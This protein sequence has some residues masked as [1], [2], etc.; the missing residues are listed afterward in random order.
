[1]ASTT[2][3]SNATICVR[4]L[5][6]YACHRADRQKQK[7]GHRP[8]LA[9]LRTGNVPGAGNTPDPEGITVDRNH[10]RRKTK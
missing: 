10:P 3:S 1:S 8:T 5:L 9:A 7:M 2:G 6:I 4:L